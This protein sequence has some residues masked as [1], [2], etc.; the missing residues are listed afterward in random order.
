MEG[1]QKD[2]TNLIEEPE[3]S[4]QRHMQTASWT[5]VRTQLYSDIRGAVK[6]CIPRSEPGAQQ[7][8]DL[9]LKNPTP[10]RAGACITGQ[11]GAG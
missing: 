6:H 5:K 2:R 4:F 3:K 7:Q 8:S 9:N 11:P 1:L 10:I